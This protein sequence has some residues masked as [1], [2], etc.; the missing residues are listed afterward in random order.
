MDK[1]IIVSIGRE[2]GSG[3]RRIG[4]RLAKSLSI[5]IYDSEIISEIAKEL[6]IREHEIEKYNEKPKSRFFSRTVRGVNNSINDNVV[7]MQFEFIRKKA[8]AGESFVLI[9][10]CGEYVLADYD[11]MVSVFITA[12]MEDRLGYVIDNYDKS[13]EEAAKVIS[14]I[15][16]E[17]SR[18]HNNYADGR[19]GDSRNYDLVINSSVL[20]IDGT[21]RL[22]RTYVKR[23]LNN[24]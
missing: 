5:N 23:F 19:W 15:D 21:A 8:D 20:G 7:D 9:G 17:R 14:S 13:E 10:R 3:G 22:L 4:R 24:K 12:D 1:Q 18:Y 16:S 11:C 2:F 6:N